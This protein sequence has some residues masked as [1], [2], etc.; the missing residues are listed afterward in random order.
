M[1]NH[2]LWIVT[3]NTGEDLA[4]RNLEC[5][6][7]DMTV[8]KDGA[9]NTPGQKG[10]GCDIPDCSGPE[11]WNEHRMT[12]TS[13]DYEFSLWKDKDLI[14]FAE[15]STYP[16][17]LPQGVKVSDNVNLAIYPGSDTIENTTDGGKNIGVGDVL[18]KVGK[19]AVKVVAT[20]I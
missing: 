6:A 8:A 20:V 18:V 15:S 19:V 12:F 14:Y 1:S 2:K 17:P 13:T 11:W 5:A 16:D 7:D 3:N 10:K 4:F 9:S